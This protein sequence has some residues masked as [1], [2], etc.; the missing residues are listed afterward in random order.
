MTNEQ[1]DAFY[2]EKLLKAKTKGVPAI[3]TDRSNSPTFRNIK[4]L[5]GVSYLATSNAYYDMVGKKP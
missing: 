2:K 3:I 1:Y 4:P 5:P